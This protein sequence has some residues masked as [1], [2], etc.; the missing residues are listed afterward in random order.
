MVDLPLSLDPF[1]CFAIVGRAEDVARSFVNAENYVGVV[2][3]EDVI[4]RVVKLCGRQGRFFL[5]A[6]RTGK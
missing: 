4:E 3:V 5:R 6:D 1:P 2:E